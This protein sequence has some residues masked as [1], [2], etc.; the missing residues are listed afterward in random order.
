M[1]STFT[2]WPVAFFLFLVACGGGGGGGSSSVS[3]QTPTASTPTPST[4]G[5]VVSPP[6]TALTERWEHLM[7]TWSGETLPTINT[8]RSNLDDLYQSRWGAWNDY[9]AFGIVRIC[10][11][12]AAL[13]NGRCSGGAAVGAYDA[14]VI[15]DALNETSPVEHDAYRLRWDGT[16][17][18][19]RELGD[20]SSIHRGDANIG[21]IINPAASVHAN[22]TVW[23]QIEVDSRSF[24][25]GHPSADMMFGDILGDDDLDI[26][27]GGFQ[28]STLGNDGFIQGQFYGPNHEEVGG[29]FER[30]GG[31]YNYTGAF[32]AVRE[33]R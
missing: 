24:L 15:G 18:V 12:G 2:L 14:F 5:G 21:V 28:H 13:T 32:G 33:E 30:T 22:A 27:R 26:I 29:I 25:W 19:V 17:Y 1:K 11:G 20:T 8:A 4:G 7:T 31:G 23:V 16:A 9:A 6:T 3:S 10:A